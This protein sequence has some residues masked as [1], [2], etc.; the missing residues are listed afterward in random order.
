MPSI[1]RVLI[2]LVAALAAFCVS[3]GAQA[4]DETPHPVQV[5]NGIAAIGWQ[6]EVGADVVMAL[7]ER[8]DCPIAAWGPPEDTGDP[9]QVLTHVPQ[10]PPYDVR[11]L[12]RRTDRIFLLRYRD[13]VYIDRLGPYVARDY[14]PYLS[15]YLPLVQR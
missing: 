2:L 13:G 3:V 10:G 11:C 9:A 12:I 1:R 6:N 8:D 14:V 7:L 4:P 15:T 5:E